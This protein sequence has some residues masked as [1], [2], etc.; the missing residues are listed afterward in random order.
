MS[1]RLERAADRIWDAGITQPGLKLSMMQKL[2]SRQLS[3]FIL[4]GAM[5][6]VGA[7]VFSIT[8][9]QKFF[10]SVWWAVVTSTSVGYG[11]LYPKSTLGRIDAMAL[12]IISLFV[13]VPVITAKFAAHL[14]V[15]SDAFTHDEQE[16]LKL[17]QKEI[18]DTQA[19]ILTLL[20]AN[21]GVDGRDSP[22]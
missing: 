11:D 10:D 22:L 18:M 19:Q 17:A 4:Y 3:V 14:I 21:N 16:G 6:L 13:L 7:T 1:G 20:A 5:I 9:D 12:M 15:N 8:E 2:A